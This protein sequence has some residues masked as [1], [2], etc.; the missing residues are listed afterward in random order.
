MKRTPFALAAVALLALLA[1]ACGK[2]DAVPASA[3]EPATSTTAGADETTT[4]AAGDTASSETTT[5]DEEAGP[6]ATPEAELRA[7]LTALLEEHVYLTGITVDGVV[8]EG[9][10]SPGATAA[11]GTLEDNSVAIGDAMSSAFDAQVGEDFL[12]LWR[13]H[14]VDYL[15]Y[16]AAKQAGDAVAASAAVD[17]L[18][19]YRSDTGDLLEPASDEALSAD[20][21][22]G[23]LEVHVQSVLAVIDATVAGSP[24][25]VPLL[26]EAAGHMPD[27]AAMLAAGIAEAQAA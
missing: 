5:G 7:D 11:A 25:E 10:A 26:R 17:R 3:G 18:D 8:R 27:T 13:G 2:D 19:Q 23:D 20:T 6:T 1:A 24:D 9:N 15:D 16:T 21:V 22:S 4:T 14:V 12:R